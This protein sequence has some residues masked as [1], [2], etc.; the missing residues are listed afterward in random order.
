MDFSDF[1]SRSSMILSA[2]LLF[3]VIGA[4]NPKDTPAWCRASMRACICQFQLSNILARAFFRYQYFIIDN[5]PLML[6]S[7]GLVLDIVMLEARNQ[8]KIFWNG[9]I[10]HLKF[11]VFPFPD[12]WASFD[13]W[14]SFKLRIGGYAIRRDIFRKTKN[15][16]NRWYH[17][18][19]YV[20]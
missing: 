10:F 3:R 5:S 18:F 17:L 7:F 19:F 8:T 20:A 2:K 12:S 15:E 13:F 6:C 1:A 14:V 11:L 4:L 16:N 9:W